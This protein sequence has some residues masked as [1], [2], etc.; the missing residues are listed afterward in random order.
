MSGSPRRTHS[1]HT[2]HD[3]PTASPNPDRSKRHHT[4]RTLRFQRLSSCHSLNDFLP[5]LPRPSF[6]PPSEDTDDEEEE[7]KDNPTEDKVGKDMLPLVSPL[8]E[9]N[10][11][12]SAQ[13]IEVVPIGG[14]YD[15]EYYSTTKT[16]EKVDTEFCSLY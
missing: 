3:L 5:R 11:E 15:S 9:S 6:L 2:T 8:L 13:T 14:R 12:S 7:E 16:M 10:P 4:V 1:S